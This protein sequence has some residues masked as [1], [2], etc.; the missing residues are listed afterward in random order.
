[1]HRVALYTERKG[2]AGACAAN[3]L[4]TCWVCV[5]G[6]YRVRVERDRRRPVRIRAASRSHR[7]H[8]SPLRET[9][10][11]RTLYASMRRDDVVCRRRRKCRARAVA[12]RL[13]NN[14]CGRTGNDV[15]WASRELYVRERIAN[16]TR[17]QISQSVVCL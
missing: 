7:L 5:L 10:H 2:V 4:C 9:H 3:V 11:R 15:V 8:G 14:I 12:L 1:M 17:R 16:G 6:E 13:T